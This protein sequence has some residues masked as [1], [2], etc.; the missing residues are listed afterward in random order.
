MWGVIDCGL[1][2]DASEDA[3]HGLADGVGDLGG[4][5]ASVDELPLLV[6]ELDS[7]ELLGSVR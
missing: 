7:E 1:E 5:L 6:E 2:G 4:N 3:R